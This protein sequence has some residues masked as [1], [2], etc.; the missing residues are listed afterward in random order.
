MSEIVIGLAAIVFTILIYFAGVQRGKRYR[1]EDA[2]RLEAEREEERRL[3]AAAARR[4]RIEAVLERYRGLAG[5]R[6]DGVKGLL[7]AGAL[8]LE[9]SDEVRELCALIDR[10]RLP[11]GI[12]EP[13]AR[14]LHGADLLRF[15]RE[16]Q[17]HDGM[18]NGDEV[19]RATARTRAHQD[20]A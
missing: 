8:N 17:L 1:A 19:E 15:L 20:G 14:Q 7:K 16:I 11:S 12:P 10:E 9:T 6:T 3:D 4:H 18:L 2:A 5:R 13:A